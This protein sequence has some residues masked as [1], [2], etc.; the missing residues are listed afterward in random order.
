MGDTVDGIYID[1][2]FE[3]IS[4]SDE[5]FLKSQTVKYLIKV[6][7]SNFTFLEKH[8]KLLKPNAIVN[9]KPNETEPFEIKLPQTEKY[10]YSPSC[11]EVIYFIFGR[12]YTVCYGSGLLDLYVAS[13]LLLAP[14]EYVNYYK[15]KL[16][17]QVLNNLAQ[18]G[19]QNVYQAAK[20]LDDKEMLTWCV[21]NNAEAPK[22][23]SLYSTIQ[24]YSE[25]SND[26]LLPEIESL[27]IV[28]QFDESN[29]LHHDKVIALISK[30]KGIKEFS[31]TVTLKEDKQIL[32]KIGSFLASQPELTKLSLTFNGNLDEPTISEDFKTLAKALGGLTSLKYLSLTLPN[33]FFVDEDMAALFAD[34][35]CK[36]QKVEEVHFKHEGSYTRGKIIARVLK[37]FSQLPLLQIFELKMDCYDANI[38]N[39]EE[40]YFEIA[41]SL[42]KLTHLKDAKLVFWSWRFGEKGLEKILEAVTKWTELETLHINGRYS[43]LCED[44]GFALLGKAL[45]SLSKIT[46]FTL[47]NENYSGGL[48]TNKG[49]A[50]L[51][52]GLPN[53]VVNLDLNISGNELITDEGFISLL[54]GLSKL[55][56]AKTFNID[57]AKSTLTDNGYSKLSLLSTLKDMGSVKFGFAK[58]GDD[59]T[60]RD[61]EWKALLKDV[62]PY[63]DFNR[64]T[65]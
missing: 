64:P 1:P 2:E 4:T 17:K 26:E 5:E 38:T 6:G 16:R 18:I 25:M 33:T 42:S 60:S 39:T 12:A 49:L 45:P 50:A 62:S 57:L 21:E 7:Y 37:G 41:D 34:A 44:S 27:D 32:T 43:I 56:N 10:Q 22:S 9:L 36:L 8:V 19:W 29:E 40:D 54:T 51:A 53:S 23:L 28:T 30:F 61:E 59:V 65:W 46:N 20:V 15:K 31:W 55:T 14:T 13:E 52:E 11:Y 58:L 63:V 24:I 35:I 47:A 48:L 3:L